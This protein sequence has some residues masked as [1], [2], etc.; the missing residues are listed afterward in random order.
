MH[1]GR[2]IRE[3]VISFRREDGL[4]CCA[5]NGEL[6]PFSTEEA[7]GRTSNH[8]CL[9]R[10]SAKWWAAACADG[11][12]TFCVGGSETGQILRLEV[13]SPVGVRRSRRPCP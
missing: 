3:R 8:F 1:R 7:P 9:L 10:I 12:G 5:N 11:T 13:T 4:L 2:Q 6:R